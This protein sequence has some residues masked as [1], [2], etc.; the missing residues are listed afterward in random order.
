[1]VSLVFLVI[2]FLVVDVI[3]LGRPEEDASLVR[4]V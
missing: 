3:V 4:A 1:M 2:S